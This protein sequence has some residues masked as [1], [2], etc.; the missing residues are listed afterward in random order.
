M[1]NI[2]PAF[3]FVMAVCLRMENIS[4][5]QKHGMAKVLG[6]LL[7][8]SG[9]AV[10]SFVRGPAVYGAGHQETSKSSARHLSK[11]DW[12][13][14]TNNQAVPVETTIHNNAMLL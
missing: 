14:G 10:Y 12:I 1:N 9:V 6:V 3:T 4:L 2:I 13:K 8:L 11:D 7:C 5:K